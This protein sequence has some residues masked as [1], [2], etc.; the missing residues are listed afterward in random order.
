MRILEL[1]NIL[2]YLLPGLDSTP[3]RSIRVHR[4]PTNSTSLMPPGGIPAGSSAAAAGS[5]PHCRNRALRP[6]G[7]SHTAGIEHHGPLERAPHG[8]LWAG[9]HPQPP[10][11]RLL[12]VD[13]R[14]KL[15]FPS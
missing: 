13:G 3:N 2:P 8:G 10:G 12:V 7:A 15:C 11:R 4:R 5:K 1:T 9:G 6:L 14:A